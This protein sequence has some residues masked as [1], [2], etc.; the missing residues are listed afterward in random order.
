M[1]L[2]IKYMVRLRCKMMVKEVLK[3]LGF[4]ANVSKFQVAQVDDLNTGH[5]NL[6]SYVFFSCLLL[7]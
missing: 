6:P 2:Y 3:K 7:Q 4:R 5:P 1:K